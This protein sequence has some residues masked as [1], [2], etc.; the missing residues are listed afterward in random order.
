MKYEIKDKEIHIIIPV[1]NSGKFRFKTRK[2]NF[3]FGK[4]F[5]TR[6]NTF[7]K[8][9]Y[10]E[11]QIGYDVTEKDLKEN[12]KHTNLT[13]L[14]FIGYNKKLKYPYELSE[15]IYEAVRIGLIPSNSLKKLGKEL[16][17][18]KE[19][20]SGKD[21]DITRK[22]TFAINGIIFEESVIQ[23]P[24]FFVSDSKNRT[25]IEVSI[26]K[27]QYATGVQPMLYFS[28]QIGSFINNDEFYGRSSKAGDKLIYIINKSNADGLLLMF[29]I[30][31]MASPAHNHDIKEIIKVLVNLLNKS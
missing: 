7:N 16:L 15:L 8:G 27:Q 4:S 13:K 3:S 29:K 12:K 14:S 30:F 9:V 1:S 2:D 24:T 26:Q 21:I 6:S 25:Q 20:L 28:I 31:G 11:W 19:F 5:A 17:S 10:L 22:G 23:L 18:Y